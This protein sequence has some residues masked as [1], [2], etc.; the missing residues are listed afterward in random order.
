M[1]LEF[2]FSKSGD[3]TC[4]I[5]GKYLH[6][7][8]NPIAESE[9]FVKNIC[10][11]FS[12][13]CVIV[14]EPAISY[15]ASFFKIRFPDAKI[16]C[17]RFLNDFRE[18]D[19]SWDFVFY[20][21]DENF[22]N[23]SENLFNALGEETLISGLFLD[24]QPS[25]NL[26]P[27]INEKCWKE[28]QKSVLKARDV[29]GT[30]SYFSKR[31]L[32]N[33]ALF[34][35]NI[36]SGFV[37]KLTNNKKQILIAASGPSLASSLCFIKKFRSEFFLI[38]VSSALL[39]LSANGIEPDITISSDGGFWAKRHLAV[40]GKENKN[41]NF[42]LEAESACFSKIYEEN[43]IIPLCYDDGL[44]KEILKAIGC[45]FMITRRNGTVAGTALEFAFS[46]TNGEIFLAGF[47]QASSPEFQHTQPNALESISQKNDS[48]LSTKETR[49]TK[50]RFGAEK[51]LEIYRNW[52]I[53]NSQ[54]FGKRV[55]RI[56][57]NYKFPYSLGEI[58]DINW[59]DFEKS[60]KIKK[61]DLS[62]KLSKST[63]SEI[64]K[65]HFKITLTKNERK[66]KI[67]SKLREI[68]SSD[69]FL[70]EVFPMD[71]VLLKREINPENKEK[72]KKNA[73]QKIDNLIEEIMKIL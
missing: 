72:I 14:T 61:S 51:S 36:K 18:F 73:R 71:S 1:S 24:W 69:F 41:H 64:I 65:N 21:A 43:E 6:S 57:D 38:A 50:S 39:P 3:K 33:A 26:F 9:K 27:E 4:S 15:C 12:P 47:D 25:K 63:E 17:I 46:L 48:R 56:S 2:S 40:P 7:K 54:K 35:K 23:L 22:E 44:E 10:V 58:K 67:I 59:N 42:A 68:S 8:Y 20:G 52:F 37:F 5:S 62:S 49:L 70:D 55:F 30:R 11:D 60:L 13:L 16:C 32:K 53:A 34:C 29:L 66:E 19:S 28:I 31:W 45:P